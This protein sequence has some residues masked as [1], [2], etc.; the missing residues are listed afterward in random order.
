MQ[1]DNQVETLVPM[2]VAT[3]LRKRIDK[4]VIMRIGEQMSKGRRIRKPK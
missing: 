2:R 4:V 3:C 1:I